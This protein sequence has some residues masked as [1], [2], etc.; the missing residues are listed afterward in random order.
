M[1]EMGDG[2]MIHPTHD[3]KAK[4]LTLPHPDAEDRR[5][6]VSQGAQEAGEHLS[7]ESGMG[8]HQVR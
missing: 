3:S 4:L 2:V 1:M 6:E 8:V 7:K 5:Y